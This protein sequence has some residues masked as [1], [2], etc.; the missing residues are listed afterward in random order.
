MITC[1]YCGRHIATDEM[2][3][4]HCGAHQERFDVENEKKNCKKC[5]QEIPVNANFCPYCGQDQAIF[6]RKTQPEKE[7]EQDMV[8]DAQKKQEEII[9]QSLADLSKLADDAM[10]NKKLADQGL[11][12]KKLPKNESKK[13]GLITSTKLLLKDTF[14]MDKRMGRADFW[15]GNLGLLLLILLYACLMGYLLVHF[16]GGLV[17]KG[18]ILNATLKWNAAPPP[19][20]FM[21]FWNF[22][23]WILYPFVSLVRMTAM[24]R[25][26]HDLER[27]GLLVILI[28]LMPFFGE[29]VVL[30]ICMAPQKVTNDRY[31]FKTQRA[32]MLDK[33]NGK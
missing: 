27:S 22:S 15:W 29:L 2:N 1:Q 25:R 12:V 24:V 26:L 23:L 13:P 3:C 33:Y 8:D 11:L 18:S 28:L 30:L 4:H 10:L 6:V 21:Y 14:I 20:W 7:V 17:M 5:Q 31:T 16:D 9:I 19:A 32:R